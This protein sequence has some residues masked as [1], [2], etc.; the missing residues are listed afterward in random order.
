MN[1]LFIIPA[2]GGSKGIPYKNIK[3]FYGKPLIY[4]SL[5]L[6]RQFTSDVNICISTDDKKIIECVNDYKYKVP[7]IRPMELS[8]DESGTYDVLKHALIHYNSIGENYDNIILLQPTSPIR[9]K[10]HINDSLNLFSTNIDMVVSVK[11][12][13]ANPYYNLFE[14]DHNGYLIKSKKGKYTRRQD[15]PKVWE[16]NG[17][18]YLIN[19]S[20]LLKYDSFGDF[21]KKKK[22]L[23]SQLYS[24]DIDNQLQWDFAEFIYNKIQNK[25]IIE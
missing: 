14:E 4:Y 13:D 8:T 18:I 21:T 2:R 25:E 24:I 20:S 19:T 12:S 9:K 10:E 3:E 6:A 11:E 22:Y 17:S 15:C 16:Y 5:D 23:M 1:S 7:F